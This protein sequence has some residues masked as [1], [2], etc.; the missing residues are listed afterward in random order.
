MC[1]WF[2]GLK[3]MTFKCIWF[4]GLK[5]RTFR[6]CFWLVGLRRGLLGVF[7]LLD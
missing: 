5:K 3:K 4:V 6:W 2:V 7:G 1:I